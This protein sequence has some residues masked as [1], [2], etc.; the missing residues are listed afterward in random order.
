M[1]RNKNI[2]NYFKNYKSRLLELIDRID[3]ENL[4]NTIDLMISTFKKGNTVYVC[5]NG[6]SAATA[7]HMQADFSFFTRYFTDFRPKVK[8]L[9][10]N[11]PLISAIGNDTSFDK[12]FVEQLKGNFNEDDILV[13]ISASGNSQN[14]IDAVDFV[15]KNGGKSIAFIGFDGGE[16]LNKCDFSIYTKGK[17]GDYG[18]IEDVHM[19]LNHFI[20]NYLSIDNEFLDIKP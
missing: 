5:G 2:D 4:V 10:D 20:V 13:C 16:L 9:T 3:I 6:G 7:S 8:A 19:I 14:L 17:K 11:L 1:E 18:P 12:I 15:K